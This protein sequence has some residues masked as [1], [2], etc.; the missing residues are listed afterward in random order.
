MAQPA[1]REAPEAPAPTAEEAFIAAAAHD[2]RDPLQAALGYLDILDGHVPEG[3]AVGRECLEAARSGLLRMRTLLE[4]MLDFA[5]AHPEVAAEP[6]D[7][8]AAVSATKRALAPLLAAAQATVSVGPLP[9]VRARADAVER[10]LQNLFTNAVK[11]RGQAP[12]RIEVWA[13]R[14][15]A[16]WV[17]A[18]RDH[19]LG[20]DPVDMGRLFR[21]FARLPSSKG[22]SGT[23][24]GLALS[25]RL[26]SAMGGRLWATSQPGQGAT[27]FL[28][29]PDPGA[30]A[31]GTAGPLE[32][33]L[34]ALPAA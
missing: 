4:G 1:L 34:T 11:Y 13:H 12:A 30:P 23:G 8:A 15:G 7:L 21:P 25:Q 17:V 14:E 2:L 3:D 5:R 29:I 6:V 18:V 20:M 31:R 28:R 19:G 22:Q 10:I 24:L 9:V 26:A 27:F 16:A 33:L 32:G